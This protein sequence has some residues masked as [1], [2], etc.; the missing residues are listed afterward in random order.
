MA[1]GEAA[2]AERFQSHCDWIAA[3]R[4]EYERQVRAAGEASLDRCRHGAWS[5]SAR[6]VSV[7][8]RGTPVLTC[9]HVRFAA[10]AQ[11]QH[12]RLSD[13][14][15]FGDFEPPMYRS[16]GS[17]LASGE[18]ESDFDVGGAECDF[19]EPVYRSLGHLGDR[20][21]S[22]TVDVEELEA[23]A[24]HVDA[25]SAVE[26]AWMRTMPPLVKRQRAFKF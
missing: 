22:G 5:A 4:A 6:R 18:V 9:R 24:A 8:A 15:E 16:A 26:A 14:V 13:A 21:A 7:A 12:E 1:Q 10:A 19:E 23:T 17:A 11:P 3:V 2:D 20:G 25:A